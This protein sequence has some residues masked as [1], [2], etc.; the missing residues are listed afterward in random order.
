MKYDM[1]V[2]PCRH[3]P[4]V[5]YPYE[6]EV[7]RSELIREWA[8]NDLFKY[9]F[10]F[11]FSPHEPKEFSDYKVPI[12]DII[13]GKLVTTKEIIIS[14][15]SNLRRHSFTFDM[16]EAMNHLDPYYRVLGVLPYWGESRYY[17]LLKQNKTPRVLYGPH[18][19]GGLRPN[20]KRLV[21]LDNEK[22]FAYGPLQS[23]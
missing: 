19:G 4:F 11:L 10:G 3:L 8:K 16:T 22:E 21:L 6:A 12:G 18:K 2:L 20:Q 13:E 23:A 15:A 17:E 1:F 5:N 9:S 14:V 7:I